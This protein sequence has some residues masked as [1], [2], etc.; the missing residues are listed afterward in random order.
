MVVRLK[1]PKTT[2]R[3]R[4]PNDEKI[5]D[6]SP[7]YNC[8]NLKDSVCVCKGDHL[9]L[10]N[11]NVN[12][13]ST[14]FKLMLTRWRSQPIRRRIHSID[15]KSHLSYSKFYLLCYLA[16]WKIPLGLVDIKRLHFLS[17]CT[18]KNSLESVL[19]P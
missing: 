12:Y 15:L 5:F 16:T 18:E 11:T 3:F 2:Y 6:F 9:F 7:L 1:S 13:L 10:N 14:I 4:W 19:K 8:S 17:C